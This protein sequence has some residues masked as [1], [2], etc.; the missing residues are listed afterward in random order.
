[1]SGSFRGQ[2]FVVENVAPAANLAAAAAIKLTDRRLYTLL[3]VATTT[4]SDHS[5]Y[6]KLRM[7]HQ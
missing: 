3:F 7:G 6:Q 4:R 1:L 5:L 2:Q